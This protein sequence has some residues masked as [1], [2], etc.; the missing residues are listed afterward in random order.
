VAATRARVEGLLSA[1]ADFC[2]ARGRVTAGSLSLLRQAQ[3]ACLEAGVPALLAAVLEAS[4]H[5]E[6]EY[7]S[8]ADVYTVYAEQIG[9]A[10]SVA[11]FFGI[12]KFT[13][14]RVLWARHRLALPAAAE[15]AG[16][17]DAAGG[18]AA[19]GDVVSA[20]VLPPAAAGG[21]GQAM[22]RE[23]QAG[24]AATGGGG[25]NKATANAVDAASTDNDDDDTATGAAESAA[26]FALWVGNGLFWTAPFLLQ[27][28]ASR[29]I[30]SGLIDNG[31]LSVQEFK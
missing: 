28:A 4:K 24:A 8:D 12:D 18:D 23:S 2:A 19:A 27:W 25:S 3:R 7:V 31:N 5:T 6:D 14:G 16:N 13:L 29:L 11:Q 30:G 22:K 20:V 10:N 1:A 9:V 17:D 15:S 26:L 21:G